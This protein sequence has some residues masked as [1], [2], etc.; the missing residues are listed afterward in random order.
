[1]ADNSRLTEFV[2]A[3]PILGYLG[4]VALFAL[5]FLVFAL[6][7]GSAQ[8]WPIFVVMGALLPIA[9]IRKAVRN[10]GESK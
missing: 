9:L 7:S 4:W 8:G 6:T 10:S 5:L 3:H 1:M 2:I